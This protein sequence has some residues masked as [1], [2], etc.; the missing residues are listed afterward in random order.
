MVLE[1]RGG[2]TQTSGNA[3]C[4]Y[5]PQCKMVIF[6]AEGFSSTLLLFLTFTSVITCVIFTC[7]K[8]QRFRDATTL[9]SRRWGL[10]V[11]RTFSPAIR[12]RP[13]FVRAFPT[14][15][16]ARD[17]RGQAESQIALISSVFL[18][19]VR[20]LHDQS[21][22]AGIYRNPVGRWWFLYHNDACTVCGIGIRLQNIW[23]KTICLRTDG[24]L[25][26]AVCT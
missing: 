23:P 13:R 22:N 6:S 26:Y 12:T 2:M 5:M 19:I 16:C 9:R 8:F 24:S 7:V 20:V 3:I 11:D 14:Y 15:A 4:E 17:R 25:L 1:R 10:S 21:M 18:A